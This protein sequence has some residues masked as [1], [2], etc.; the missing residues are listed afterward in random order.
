ML[1]IC[2]ISGKAGGADTGPSPQ[3]PKPVLDNPRPV[4]PRREPYGTWTN[5]YRV[6]YDLNV[7]RAALDYG[8][9]APPQPSSTAPST[10][11]A[12]ERSNVSAMHQYQLKWDA[13]KAAPGASLAPSLYPSKIQEALEPR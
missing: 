9:P 11:E 2:L 7:D 12:A 1:T 4:T 6:R 5:L 8:L 3:L 13:Q 10:T